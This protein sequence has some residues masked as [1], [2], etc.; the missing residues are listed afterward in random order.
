MGRKK[1]SSGLF[2][3][4][5]V[6][7]VLIASL[8]KEVWVTLL[9]IAGIVF[10]V[11]IVQKRSQINKRS[12]KDLKN[13]E[14]VSRL[15][16]VSYEESTP[17]PSYRIPS[18]PSDVV[19]N[20]RW[21]PADESVVVAGYTFPSGLIYVGSK[22]PGRYGQ[23]DPSLIDP[24]VP[25]EKSGNLR[26]RLMGYWPSYS[27]ISPEARGAYLT[28][29]STGRDDPEADVGYVF[30]FFYGLERRIL[31]DGPKDRTVEQERLIIRNE[32][33]RLLGIYGKKSGSVQSYLSGFLQL[34]DSRDFSEKLYEQ[35]VPSLGAS[36][37]L[38]FYLRLALGQAAVDAIPVPPHLALA[39][40]MYDP[41]ITKRTPVT[42]CPDEFSKLFSLKYQQY[43]HEGIKLTVNK[44]KLSFN[45][46][47]ASSALQRVEI[48]SKS[49]GNIPDVAAVVGPQKKLQ[50]IVEECADELDSY[51]RFLGRNAA[52]KD[53]IDA[54]L[55]LPATLWPVSARTALALI[56]EQ[57]GDGHLIL[58]VC[59]LIGKFGDDTD[60]SKDKLVA[61]AKALEGEQ[62]GM[63]PDIISYPYALKAD[64]SIL[65]YMLQ[66]GV[67]SVR[68]TPE[69]QTAVLTLQLGAAVANSDGSMH[70]KEITHLNE[71]IG[72]WEHLSAYHLNR[73]RAHLNLMLEKPVT[74]ARLKK[75]LET[76][77]F[78][79]RKTIINFISRIALADGEVVPE[80]IAF[81][82]KVYKVFEVDVAGLYSF[83]HNAKSAETASKPV[84][85]KKTSK[86]V[87]DHGK[88]ESLRKDTE[89][90]S[91]LLSG[92]F[93]DKT[94][95]SIEPVEVADD[96]KEIMLGLDDTHAAFLRMLMAKTVWSRQELSDIANDLDLMIDGAIETINEASFEKHDQAVI[97]GDDP[98]EINLDIREKVLV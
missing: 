22:L 25:V 26:E 74:L 14:G 57:V 61:L 43:H 6:A 91:A 89:N 62:I 73:L 78:E 12:G 46:R 88:I 63:E 7:I 60:L 1:T 36:Y 77:H 68:T 95:E 10:V 11:R 72:K 16:K 87:L 64:D 82:E 96:G 2:A 56:K 31:I 54:L 70:E 4:I 48:A 85:T 37:E 20:A 41:L 3:G 86:V 52:K 83:L 67:P 90:V 94:E 58:K 32:V 39:W 65:I 33:E 75:R 15:F 13:D 71:Q 28:W 29:L 24:R 17:M 92:I 21:I 38:P 23:Q 79:D 81:L 34:I 8:P 9:V 69:Y 44:T 27:E 97:E 66:T 47:A 40:A 53:S 50:K 5:I 80:E 98:V 93:T 45:Y 19:Q 51:S 30:L 49:F 59:E 35:P 42:R 18:P 84:A 76:L 55:L